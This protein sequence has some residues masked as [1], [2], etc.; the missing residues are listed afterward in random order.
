MTL[1]LFVA[2]SLAAPP[3]LLRGRTLRRWLG[4]WMGAWLVFAA[5][6]WSARLLRVAV[7]PYLGAVAF[8]VILTAAFFA[9][10]AFGS[11]VR[12]SAGRAALAALLF[13]LVL[14][15]LMM[16]TP[17]D[18]DEPYYLLI[19]ES[20]VRDH[21]LDLSNQYRDLPHSRFGAETR[22]TDLRPQP[23]DPV[24]RGGAQRSRHEPFLAFLLVPGYAAAGLPGA[25]ATMALFAALLAR[26][27]V[28]LFEEEGIPDSSTRALFPLIAFG[29][30]IVFYAARIWP[31]VPAALCFV[32]AVRGVR[33]RRAPRWIAALLALVLLKLRFL[34]VAV[35]L[36][37][38][39]LRSRVQAAVAAAVILIPLAVAWAISG[40]P[41]NVHAWWELLPGGARDSL[42]G[43][44]GLAVDGMDGLAF[45]APLYLFGLIAI[46]RWRSMPAAFRLGISAA[47]LYVVTLIPRSEWYGGWAPPLRYVVVFMPILALGVASLWD[48]IAAGLLLLATLWTIGLVIHGLAYPWRLFHI[49]NGENVLGE[50]LSALTHADVSRL[51]PSAIR[52]NLAFYVASAL[53]VVMLIVFRNGRSV[54]P[55]TVALLLALAALYA[56]TP[57]ERVEFEDAH[58]IHRGGALYPPEYAPSRFV[59]RGGWELHAGDA[60]EFLFR[61]GAARLEYASPRGATV[62]IGGRIVTLPP[63]A[64]YGSVRVVIPRSGRVELRCVA[65]AVNVDRIEHE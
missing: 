5:L 27:T 21:D 12:W 59:Y 35:V 3:L 49:A 60:L 30:P 11:E 28:R 45:Q 24:G 64:E 62:A 56:R 34:L 14:V 50:W 46:A 40:S 41:A 57:G 33:Q 54:T 55:A 53:F 43:L 44:F 36:L 17:I 20:L 9:F 47:A 42:R 63:T 18:G 61:G 39:A 13:Y 22:R 65:G 32:E 1:A 52:P 37:T 4:T 6:A 19:T 2:A 51:F 26:S 48:R 8:G 23:G 29:P 38:R 16:R 7:D 58:V 25:L 15:P 31:E 10:V